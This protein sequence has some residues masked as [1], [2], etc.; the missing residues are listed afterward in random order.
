MDECI[1]YLGDATIFSTLDCNSWYWH[2]EVDEADKDKT[3]F[4]SHMGLY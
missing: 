3:T 1:D 2:V 4:T